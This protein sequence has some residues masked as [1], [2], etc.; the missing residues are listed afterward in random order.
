MSE[1]PGDYT[2]VVARVRFA[3]A[4]GSEEA[5]LAPMRLTDDALSYTATVFPPDGAVLIGVEATKRRAASEQE[6]VVA[7]ADVSIL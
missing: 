7:R 5:W 1:E 6:I 3:L 4:D 2:V